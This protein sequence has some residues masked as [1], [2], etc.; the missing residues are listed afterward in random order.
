M[1]W[2]IPKTD[3]K[4]GDAPNSG[5]FNRIEGNV[6][7]LDKPLYG[8]TSGA[9]NN[10]AVSIDGVRSYVP[11]LRTTIKIHVASTGAST[12]NVNGLGAKTIKKP[13]GN[14]ATNLKANGVYTLVYDGIN[15]ILQGEG[16]EG[17][18]QP[19]DVL[20]GKTF[21][22]DDDVQT[23]TLELT[24]TATTAKVLSPYTFYSMDPKTKQTGS[25]IPKV[26]TRLLPKTNH[27][28]TIPQGYYDYDN[29]ISK[30]NDNISMNSGTVNVST[31]SGTKTIVSNVKSTYGYTEIHFIAI[32]LSFTIYNMRYQGSIVNAVDYRY[33]PGNYVGI[34]IRD[35][36]GGTPY[37]DAVIISIDYDDS[38]DDFTLDIS[39]NGDLDIDQSSLEIDWEI[40]GIK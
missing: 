16:G 32:T 31:G 15:F 4:A 17:N 9:A 29:V 25:I 35:E 30:M 1:A 28:V 39:N 6:E 26:G 34:F 24:G 27:T 36:S 22:N 21:T 23:G 20:K 13:N 37:S 40:I 14:N 33:Q 12:I 5:D 11:G 38:T 8:V 18:A 2:Q 7:E 3:W 10:Y 19:G